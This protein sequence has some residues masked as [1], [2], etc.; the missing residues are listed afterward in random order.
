MEGEVKLGEEEVGGE[1]MEDDHRPPTLL[2]LSS[3]SP[4][5][6]TLSKGEEKKGKEREM[7]SN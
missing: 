3:L 7:K 6:S 2:P 4:S 5:L 1:G